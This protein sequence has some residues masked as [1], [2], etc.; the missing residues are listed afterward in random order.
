MR[1]F[2]LKILKLKQDKKLSRKTNRKINLLKGYLPFKANSFYCQKNG[3]AFYSLGYKS[4][5]AELL[6]Q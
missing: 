6:W 4:K 1:S 3:L 5:I 2:L